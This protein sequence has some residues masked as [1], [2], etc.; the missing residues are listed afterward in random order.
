[1][2][3]F[4][5]RRSGQEGT[6]A[7]IDTADMSVDE[8]LWCEALSADLR[9]KIAAAFTQASGL[10]DVVHRQGHRQ[11][12]IGELVRVPSNQWISTIDIERSEGAEGAGGGDFVLEL[13]PAN[14]A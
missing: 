10:D 3:V 11:E 7:Q 5:Q 6:C 4:D 8:V 2:P 9:I 12:V 13:W 14:V 1:M